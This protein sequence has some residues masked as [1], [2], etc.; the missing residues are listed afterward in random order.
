MKRLVVI[1][2]KSIFYRGYYAM[3]NLTTSDGT[4]TGGVYGF[5]SLS[6]ELIKKLQPDYV[7]VAWDK[8]GTNIR[9]RRELYSEYKAGR[10][11]APEDFYAQ[12]P[13]LRELLEAFGWPLYELDDYEADDIMGAFATQAEARG[14]ETCLVTS[15]LDALQL[16]SPLTK[17]YAI[18]QGLTRVEEFTPAQFQQKYGLQTEQ[19]LDLKALMGDNSDNLPGVAGVGQKTATRLLQQYQSLDGVYQHLDEQTGALHK[20]LLAGRDSAYL[21]R[22]VAEIWR[23][24][25]VTLDWAVADMADCNYQRVAEILERLEFRSLIKRLPA[26]MRL[27][28][29]QPDESLPDLELANWAKAPQSVQ[30]STEVFVLID[31]QQL[32]LLPGLATEVVYQTSCRLLDQAARQLLTQAKVIALDIKALYHGLH[33]SGVELRLPRVHDVRQAAFLLDPLHRQS[34]PQSDQPTQQL[35]ALRQR[36]CQQQTALQQ[37]PDL[38]RVVHQLD[39]PV[40]YPLYQMER[41]GMRLDIDQLATMEVTLTQ[42]LA[43]LEAAMHKLVGCSFNPASPIQLSNVLFTKLQLPTTGIKRGKTKYST[44]QKELNKLRDQHPIIRLIERYRELSKLL[45][46]YIEALPRL[47]DSRQRLHTTF[48]QDTTSTGRLSSTNPNL[49][50]IPVRTELGRRIRRAFVPSP[51][52]MFVSADYAQFELRLAAVLAGD[53]ALIDDFNQD[54]DIH[55]KTAAEVY[56]IAPTEVD[57]AQRRA[58]KVINFG[59]LYGMSPHGLSTATGMSF[60]E[61]KRFIEHYFQLRQP[62]RR[63]LDSILQQARQ[64][65]FVNSYFGRRRPTPDVKSSN[66]MVRSGAERAAMNMPIQGTEADL[67]K[68]AMIRLEDKLAGLAEP[69]LQVHDSILVECR[70]EDAS[71]VAE[72]MRTEMEGICPELPIR[73]K[74]DVK[75]GESWEKV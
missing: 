37:Q 17:V 45:S 33:Q 38:A 50:N 66:Y 48:N 30:D 54:V 41:R 12:I 23:D 74:V 47:V 68:L 24:A 71:R 16:V 75:I 14:V 60:G 3:P 62:I 42:E 8:R 11:P 15:D 25:P 51:G 58:A 32:Y 36:Y 73:L 44:G 5:V 19:F 35:A 61:A 39:F 55:T 7:A 64:Q 9:R 18:K 53:Q 72:L 57:S 40:I 29:T 10:K 21:T 26:E 49:Q 27:V 69:V 31:N 56:G 43:A 34:L 6:L 59:V 65:G 70:P 13:I 46:T 67:M 2:G 22:R 28:N 52:R 4:P 1:D 63:Y 20:K